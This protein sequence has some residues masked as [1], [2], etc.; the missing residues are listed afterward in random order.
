MKV[1]V[2]NEVV[3]DVID[4]HDRETCRRIWDE[5]RSRG[6]CGKAYWDT[7]TNTM[8]L[9]MGYRFTDKMYDEL[10][11]ICDEL[12]YEYWKFGICSDI[13]GPSIEPL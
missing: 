11:D 13:S 12:G 1:E 4:Y 8:S 2:I 5:L 7:E 9:A 10:C 6:I 3:S